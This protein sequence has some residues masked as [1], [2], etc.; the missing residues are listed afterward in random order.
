MAKPFRIGEI[1]ATKLSAEQREEFLSF[2]RVRPPASTIQR[3]L[4]DLTGESV[5]VSAIQLWVNNTFPTGKEAERLRL[6][7]QEFQG[8]DISMTKEWLLGKTNSLL[9]ELHN[10]LDEGLLEEAAPEQLIAM[11]SNLTREM[12]SIADSIA[13]DRYIKDRTEL[14]LAGAHR[15]ADILEITFKDTQ[16]LAAVQSAIRSALEQI[17]TEILGSS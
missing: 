12:K 14:E 13:K 2:C 8:M 16:M 3:Y 11:T 9:V 1:L 5:G 15:L 6:L 17:E 10:K 4:Q 7:A